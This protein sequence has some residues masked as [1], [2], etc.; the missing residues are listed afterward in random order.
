MAEEPARP[1]V[2]IEDYKPKR[3]LRAETLDS[4]LSLEIPPR[5]MVL[6]PI[7]HEQGLAMLHSWRGIGKTYS[8]LGIG[9]AVASGGCFLRW[10]APSPRKVLYIDGEMPAVA[11][12]ERL[13]A[14]VNGSPGPEP[15]PGAFSLIT[16]DLQER[17]IPD[18]ATV[19]GQEAIEEW[20][21][22]GCDLLILDNLSSLVR[23][24]AGKVN[25]ADGWLVMQE[26]LLGLRRR[27]MSALLVH[28]SGKGGS[29]RGTSRREDVLD[30]VI[31]LR[32]PKDYVPAEGA[33]FEVHLEKA[34]SVH[35]DAANPFEAR[36]EVRD[37]AATWTLKDLEDTVTQ[38]VASLLND[39]LTQ[40]E[41][42]D[43][44]GI[45]LGTVSRHKHKAE[46]EGLL[47]RSNR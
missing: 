15:D 32:R 28:H 14:L 7:L 5:E 44:L 19:G 20:L 1:V 42:A 34:R 43:E 46:Q 6:D 10:K 33:R 29:Q 16:P 37:G 45:G 9:Y 4:F 2:A 11:M 31:S 47:N 27:G 24:G 39:G 30:T 12:Q 26:W 23:A 21:G 18:L 8:A 35:G 40:R 25:E 38:R 36:L 41:V 13:A 3:Q 22:D 17:G